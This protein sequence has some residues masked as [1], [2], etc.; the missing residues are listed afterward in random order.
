[1][2]RADRLE[3]DGRHRRGRRRVIEEVSLTVHADEV[4]AVLGR[5]GSGKSTLL[6][7]L[8]GL[9]RPTRADSCWPAS[10]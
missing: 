5:S 10:G 6:H 4:V 3:Q 2:L 7:L 8:G 9:D 1:M